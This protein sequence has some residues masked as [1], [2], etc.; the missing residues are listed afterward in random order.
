MLKNIRLADGLKF[1]EYGGGYFIEFAGGEPFCEKAFRFASVNEI[2]GFSADYRFNTCWMKNVSGGEFKGLPDEIQFMILRNGGVYTAV[3]AL[4]HNS[5]RASIRAEGRDLIVTA[6]TGDSGTAV[7]SFYGVYAEEGGSPYALVK[8]AAKN[9]SAF[10]KTCK[11]VGEKRFPKFIDYF[12][13]C[14]YNAFYD[15]I[16]EEKILSVA[17][18]FEKNGQKIGFLITDVGW[19][20]TE[21]FYLTALAPDAKKFPGGIRSYAKALKKKYGV[22]YLLMWQTFIGYWTGMRTEDIGE[23]DAVYKRFYIPDRFKLRVGLNPAGDKIDTAGDEFYPSNIYLYD[24][25][26]PRD[27]GGFYETYHRLI[28]EGGADGVKVDSLTYAEA[29]GQ[30]AG[31]RVKTAETVTRGLESSCKKHFGGEMIYCSSCSND[32]LYNMREGG[33][34]RTSTDYF[35]EIPGSHGEHVLT[36]VHTTFWMGEFIIPDWDMFQSGNTA[37]AYHAKARAISGG[38]VYCTDSLHK[39]DYGVIGAVA[40]RDGRAPRCTAFARPTVRSLFT[41]VKSERRPVNIFNTNRYNWVLGSFNCCYDAEKELAVSDTIRLNEIDGLT[42]GRFAVLSDT[43]GFLG[44]FGAEDSLNVEL[45]AFG[46]EIFT[47]SPIEKGYAVLGLEGKYNGG[48]FV[49]RFEASENGVKIEAYDAG[50]VWVY[51]EKENGVIAIKV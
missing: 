21:G 38:P 2:D 36:N 42:G 32:F 25:G 31:G 20:T 51:S 35:P 15:D 12:G 13:Y 4:V 1:A 19:Q 14:T 29:L 41:D 33:V 17:G 48:A 43:R 39:Q 30:G 24:F 50:T 40:A 18:E 37:G 10:L 46:A 7:R 22:K 11:T 45:G 6:E 16:S 34:T 26:T 44:V 23:I 27:Y 47:V 9:I 49:K 28:R 5:C 3:Y 8:N